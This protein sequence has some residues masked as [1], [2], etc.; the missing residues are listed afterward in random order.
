MRLDAYKDKDFY[1]IQ[2][3][4]KTFVIDKDLTYPDVKELVN[5]DFNIKSVLAYLS[6]GLRIPKD[7]INEI[8][9]LGD[10][11]RGSAYRFKSGKLETRKFPGFYYVPGFTKYAL[12]RKGELLNVE[13]GKKVKFVQNGAYLKASIMNDIGKADLLPKHRA[14]CLVFKDYKS[15]VDDMHVNHDDSDTLNNDLDNIYFCTPKFNTQHYHENKQDL[16]WIEALNIKTGK[17]ATAKNAYEIGRKTHCNATTVLKYLLRD[18]FVPTMSGVL[19][20]YRGDKSRA[21]PDKSMY[22]TLLKNRTGFS[23]KAIGKNIYLNYIETF[24]TLGIAARTLGFATSFISKAI[25]NNLDIPS[26]GW[27]FRE[28]DENGNYDW[29]EYSDVEIKA[30]SLNRRIKQL[31]TLSSGTETLCF[32]SWKDIGAYFNR[33]PDTLRTQKEDT[34]KILNKYNVKVKQLR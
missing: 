26:N 5:L 32:C 23:R 16:P 22:E 8:I 31:Y 27:I 30:M 13:S 2:L 7:D 28:F 12:S 15:D 18:D 10:D 33:N 21:W 1:E 11:V 20:R 14:L 4:E 9:P 24:E 29:P 19:F 34:G 6:K 25:E 17:V 3:R